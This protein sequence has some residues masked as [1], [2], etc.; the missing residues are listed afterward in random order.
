MEQDDNLR[1]A[2]AQLRR[3]SSARN[4]ADANEAFNALV[5]YAIPAVGADCPAYGAA[6]SKCLDLLLAQRAVQGWV[7]SI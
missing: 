6:L 4:D 1:E 3:L 5:H 2:S 7:P